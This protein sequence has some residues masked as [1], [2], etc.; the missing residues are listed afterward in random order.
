MPKHLAWFCLALLLLAAP[1]AQAEELTLEKAIELALQQNPALKQT[2]YQA[3]ASNWGFAKSFSAWLPTAT[4]DENWTHTDPDTYTKAKNAAQLENKLSPGAAAP[5]YRDNFAKSIN[6]VQPIFNGIG[7][8]VTIDTAYLNRRSAHLT[9]EDM[10]LQTIENVKVAYYSVLTTRALAGVA[11]EALT[12]A[13]ESLRLYRGRLAVGQSTQSD[14]LRYEAQE[15]A[16]DGARIAADNNYALAKMQLATLIGGAVE[17]D[18]TLPAIQLVVT[19]ADETRVRE[20]TLAGVKTPLPIKSHPAVK[21]METTNDIAK[22]Q[23]VGSVGKLLPRI[24]FLYNYDWTTNDQLQPNGKTSWVMGIGVQIPFFQGGGAV[25]GIGQSVELQQATWEGVDS[26]ERSFLQRAHAAQ[27]NLNSAD[28]QVV[29]G[30]RGEVAA[31]ANLDII[32][33]RVEL[34]M[35]TI[36]DLLDAQLAYIQAKSDLIGAVGSFR[37]A[38]AEWDYVTAKAKD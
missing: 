3:T 6:V 21:A 35:N 2:D 11:L 23:T 1:A 24:N 36:L 8:W 30:R 4:Y 26:F 25:S 37:N 20:A 5:V 28:Q 13:R 17:A 16:A 32:T 34:G 9:D 14:V 31:Q 38:M 22:Q 18:L 33:K 7:E 12:M 27:M 10:R 19:D 29:A 15:A